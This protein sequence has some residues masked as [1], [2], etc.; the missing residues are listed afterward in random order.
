M[1]TT[2][3]RNQETGEFELV[4]PGGATTDTTLSQTGKP[5]DAAAVG[6]A[7]S[8]Y[9]QL[10]HEHTNYAPMTHDHEEYASKHMVY[11]LG[12]YN[13]LDNSNFA[14]PVNQRGDVSYNTAGYTIDRWK[15]SSGSTVTVNDGSVT[16]VGNMTQYIE[17]LLINKTYTF[18]YGNDTDIVIG[19]VNYDGTTG[20]HSVTV[21]SGTW[22]WA[23]LYYGDFTVETLPAYMPNKYSTELMECMRYYQKYFSV[24][25][26]PNY[27]YYI[28]STKYTHY[29]SLLFV[30][31]LHKP[32]PQV[33]INAASMTNVGDQTLNTSVEVNAKCITP[34]VA[35][36][37]AI[38]L[39]KSLTVH[40]EV[41]AD[42]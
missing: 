33:T 41:S 7:L 12:A 38:T 14:N 22:T 10:T 28:D 1:A 15:I 21:P 19:N 40:F 3:V 35:Y 29:N 4:G 11:N 27:Q 25:F 37:G 36:D 18:A 31:P 9:S 13:L 16:V 23:A 30:V 2:Y 5:A 32:T 20:Y 26:N 24:H 34:I 17:G 42:L 6:N 8:G 39:D